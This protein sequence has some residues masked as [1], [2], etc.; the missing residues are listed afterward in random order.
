MKNVLKY[1]SSTW[2]SNI[3]GS[4]LQNFWYFKVVYKHTFF[5]FDVTLLW[6]RVKN[7]IFTSLS[8]NKADDKLVTFSFI[9]Y[10]R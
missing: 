7:I 5:P 4:P 8:A 2:V 10:A 6:Y 1:Y 3:F 9:L